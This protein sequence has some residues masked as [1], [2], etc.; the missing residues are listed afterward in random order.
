M[1]GGRIAPYNVFVSHGWHD[2]WIA[3]KMA[4]AIKRAQATAFIDIFDVASGDRIE[5]KV[6]EGLTSCSELVSLLTPWSVDRNW[7]WSEIAGAWALRKR[8]VGVMCG[9]TLDD[10]DKKHGGLAVL[11]P[12]NVITLNDFDQYIRELKA[13]VGKKLKA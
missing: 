3:Q 12:T 10:I 2:R 8:Y 4:E 9:L 6:H 13:R 5:P 1:I 7:V 11:S